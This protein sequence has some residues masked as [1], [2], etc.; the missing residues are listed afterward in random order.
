MMMIMVIIS[1]PFQIDVTRCN[2]LLVFHHT[3]IYTHTYM[4]VDSQE[5]SFNI[6][7]LVTVCVVQYVD[8]DS[9]AHINVHQLT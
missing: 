7:S 9:C 6:R 4:C 8:Y 5:I 2:M 1:P 3:Q